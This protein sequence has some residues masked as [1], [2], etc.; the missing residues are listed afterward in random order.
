[1][2][3]C[4]LP[5]GG[6]QNSVN[7]SETGSSLVSAIFYALGDDYLFSLARTT[8]LC[9]G[10]C[11]GCYSFSEGVAVQSHSSQSVF[12][13]DGNLEEREHYHCLAWSSLN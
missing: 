13:V 7:E 2:T 1:M 6:N 3:G 8:R 9:Q 4:H 10:D 12:E 5:H 11:K